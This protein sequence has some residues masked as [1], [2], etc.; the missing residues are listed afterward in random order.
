[1]GI[2]ARLL[3]KTL[4]TLIEWIQL[5]P[6]QPEAPRHQ[7]T[8]MCD[9]GWR[10]PHLLESGN[11]RARAAKNKPKKLSKSGKP[12]ARPQER[13]CNS[14]IGIFL[15]YHKIGI[16]I[17]CEA[18]TSNT[19]EVLAVLLSARI[20]W[21][22]GYRAD[23]ITDCQGAIDTVSRKADE[24]THK[25]GVK[26]QR[27]RKF[28]NQ[29]VDIMVASQATARWREELD[30]DVCHALGEYC[31]KTGKVRITHKKSEVFIE[32]VFV[33]MAN[34]DDAALKLVAAMRSLFPRSEVE[35]KDR[36][37]VKVLNK[38]HRRI[39]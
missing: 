37:V 13:A 4:D 28:R 14:G 30:V 20:A 1:M 17:P 39:R 33:T 31:Q 21:H 35:R 34:L 22:L 29:S 2:I 18:D 5:P 7:L 32:P 9:A 12:R 23:I 24:Y 6:K 16:S 11:K 19:A 25:T 8:I 38:S 10:E 3:L 36:K 26:E 27:K 15:M